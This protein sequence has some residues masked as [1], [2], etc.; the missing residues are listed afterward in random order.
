MKK[1]LSAALG[2]ALVLALALVPAFADGGAA[3]SDMSGL[4]AAIEAAQPG[5]VITLAPGTYTPRGGALTIDKAVSLEGGGT[6]TVEFNGAIVYDLKDAIRGSRVELRNLSI[7]AVTG[8]DCGAAIVSGRGWVLAL[9][10][11]SFNGWKYGAAI[12]PDCRSCTLDVSGGSFNCFCAV[13]IS[14]HGGNGV[15]SLEPAGSGLFEYHKYNGDKAAYFYDYDPMNADYAAADYTPGGSVSAAWPV[16]ARI[17]DRFYGSLDAALKA[18]GSGDTVYAL[19]GSESGAGTTVT[20]KAGVTLEIREGVSVFEGVVNNGTVKNGGVIRGGIG[21]EG[22]VLTLVRAEPEPASLDVSVTDKSGRAYEGEPGTKDFYLPAGDYTF[23]FSGEGYYS[24]AVNVSV[25][26]DRYQIVR[27]SV[28]PKLS[29]SDVDSSD[30]FYEYVFTAYSKG[31]MQGITET[32][33]APG[34]TVTRAMAATI[35]YRLAG[36][37]AMPDS[38]WGYPYADVEGSAWY[39][40]AVYWARQN[41]IVNGTGEDT[42]SPDTPVTREQL[43]AMLY[44][45]AAFAGQSTAAS[46]GLGGFTDASAISSWAREAAAWVSERGIITGTDGN[47][48]DPQGQATRAQLAAMLCRMTET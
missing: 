1:L 20:V 27:Q 13:S 41:N 5:D 15:Q 39:A 26:P 33:F 7:N 11:C 21:G 36:E 19:T 8:R 14:D 38:D 23:A 9:E 2:L 17:G 37:P 42:F 35:I 18:A 16:S 6:G 34:G 45:Y 22:E 31:L 4:E 24:T 25:T 40:K 30:W 10:N 44:R 29:F 46:G 3:V 47:R 12:Y 48:F 28:D 43:A 32:S